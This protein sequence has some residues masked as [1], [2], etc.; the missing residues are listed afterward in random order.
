VRLLD[1]VPAKCRPLF[2][3]L[4]ASGLRISEAI[5][6]RWSALV[7]DRPEPHL[8][9]RRAIVKGATVAPK[10]RHRARLIPLTPELAA[11]LRAHRPCDAVDDAF[12]FPGR[13]GGA[14]DQGNLRRRVLVPA[15]DRAARLTLVGSNGGDEG[16]GTGRGDPDHCS[17]RAARARLFAPCSC[18]STIA[19]LSRPRAWAALV[20]LSRVRWKSPRRC[21]NSSETRRHT[22]KWAGVV[23]TVEPPMR[24]PVGAG[25]RFRQTSRTLGIRFPM[26]LEVIE[27]EPNHR[28]A[29]K[30]VWPARSLTA[31]G[32]VSTQP[33]P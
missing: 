12:A 13:H 3:L 5:G 6:L 22:R 23:V 18:L 31:A 15:L 11:T 27:Y 20:A 9:V 19:T 14:C 21:S 24:G 1:G 8:R 10:S 30:S 25:S 2:E 17:G 7:L 26:L 4:A 33:R 32:G 29:P 28:I 16:G